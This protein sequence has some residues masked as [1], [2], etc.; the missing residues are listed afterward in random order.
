MYIA[1]ESTV[2][3]IAYRVKFKMVIIV[4]RL[5]FKMEIVV[6]RVKRKMEWKTGDSLTWTTRQDVRWCEHSVIYVLGRW[7]PFT[8]AVYVLYAL[9]VYFSI[10]HNPHILK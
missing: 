8:H 7:T 9:F 2:D 10:D 6:Y 5:K 4:Y 3:I 1:I